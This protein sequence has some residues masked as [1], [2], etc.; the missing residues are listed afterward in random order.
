MSLALVSCH[1][2]RLPGHSFFSVKSLSFGGY[3]HHD[4][5]EVW[6]L[7]TACPQNPSIDFLARAWGKGFLCRG[8]AVPSVRAWSSNHHLLTFHVTEHLRHKRGLV[9]AD[10]PLFYKGSCKVIEV[11]KVYFFFPCKSIFHRI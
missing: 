11:V 4:V 6:G 5:S 1:P 9:E 2:C 8:A 3:C 10:L 7:E